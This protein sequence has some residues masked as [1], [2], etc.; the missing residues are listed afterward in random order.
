M[1]TRKQEIGDD[2][3]VCILNLQIKSYKRNQNHKT[4]TLRKA[5]PHCMQ[6]ACQV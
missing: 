4:M 6:P 2:L 5:A 1:N 3:G